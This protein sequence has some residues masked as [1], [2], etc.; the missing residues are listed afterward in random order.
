MRKFI[1]IDFNYSF[2]I[3]P[4]IAFAMPAT[5]ADPISAGSYDLAF[6]LHDR[7]ALSVGATFKFSKQFI[8]I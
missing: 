7:T 4:G 6:Y 1:N 2:T 5:Y 8:N 3:T